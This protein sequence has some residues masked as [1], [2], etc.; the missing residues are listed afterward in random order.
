VVFDYLLSDNMQ[1]LQKTYMNKEAEPISFSTDALFKLL[2]NFINDNGVL[3]HFGLF[4][5]NE[6]GNLILD[7]I[8]VQNIDN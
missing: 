2:P 4:I 1:Y 8:E 3:Y 5:K 6:D 7:M